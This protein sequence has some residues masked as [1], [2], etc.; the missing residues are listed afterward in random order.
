MLPRRLPQATRSRQGRG[1]RVLV[2]NRDGVGRVDFDRRVFVFAGGG[3][4]E[5]RNDRA[6]RCRVDEE[7]VIEDRIEPPPRGR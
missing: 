5:R 6:T 3:F 2:S 4:P 1:A 7:S